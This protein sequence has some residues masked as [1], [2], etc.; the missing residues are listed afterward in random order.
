[1]VN[2]D[3]V[4]SPDG[5]SLAVSSG[6]IWIIP[7]PPLTGPA[8][9]VTDKTNDGPSYAHSWSPDGK[10]I[11][12]CAERSGHFDVYSIPSSARKQDKPETKLTKFADGY[13]DGPD[14]S[15]NGQQV[16][17]NSNRTGTYQIWRTDPQGGYYQQLT[18][19]ARENC[20]SP[21]PAHTHTTHTHTHTHTPRP[22]PPL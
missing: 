17:F 21:S 13:N 19:D 11:A 3:H 1:M 16:Y 18:A 9:Q 12:Y 4:L 15:A 5:K 10:T 8:V 6:N 22:H 14:Y 7:A 20:E 2:N